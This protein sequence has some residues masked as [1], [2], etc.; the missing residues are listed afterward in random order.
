MSSPHLHNQISARQHYV[1]T[2][3][4]HA[5]HSPE[6]SVASKRHRFGPASRAR[7]SAIA[8]AVAAGIATGSAAIVTSAAQTTD[9]SAQTAMQAS[10]IGVTSASFVRRM[11]NL[12]AAGYVQVLC[13]VDGSLMFNPR[14]RRYATVRA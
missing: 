11:R 1:A 10:R 3:R 12:E 7:R 8:V 2:D 14:T 9:A 4:A 6:P 13:K 5:Q